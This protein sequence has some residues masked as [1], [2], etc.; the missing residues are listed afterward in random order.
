MQ[1]TCT[2]PVHNSHD[3]SVQ[4]VRGRRSARQG[5]ERGSTNLEGE[6]AGLCGFGEVF[7]GA[8]LVVCVELDLETLL[9]RSNGSAKVDRQRGE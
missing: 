5:R 8:L 4:L 2:S 9:A 3:Q 7:A 1:C 6:G